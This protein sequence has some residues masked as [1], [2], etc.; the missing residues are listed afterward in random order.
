MYLDET[1]SKGLGRVKQRS[2]K[3]RKKL[4]WN[5]QV[6]EAVWEEKG[7]EENGKVTLTTKN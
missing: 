7:A 5:Q 3:K 6:Y 4:I 2:N 1:L